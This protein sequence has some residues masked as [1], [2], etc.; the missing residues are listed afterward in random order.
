MAGKA[1][2]LVHGCHP[3]ETIDSQSG[4]GYKDPGRQETEMAEHIRMQ[5]HQVEILFRGQV[6][7]LFFHAADLN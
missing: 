6:L 3:A 4:D 7:K 2:P 1:A 5:A